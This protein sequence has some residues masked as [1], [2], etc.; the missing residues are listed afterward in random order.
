MTISDIMHAIEDGCDKQCDKCPLVMVKST[1]TRGG[2]LCNMLRD[3]NVSKGI[4]SE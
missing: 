3:E 4:W 2:N 1:H